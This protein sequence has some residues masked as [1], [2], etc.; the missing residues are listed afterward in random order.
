M[1]FSLG[2]NTA[3][4]YE[5][6]S[7]AYSVNKPDWRTWMTTNCTDSIA[8]FALDRENE[9]ASSTDA[10][11]MFMRQWKLSLLKAEPQKINTNTSP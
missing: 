9:Y 1:E 3:T 10:N 7:V 8:L 5:R 6:Y 2:F 11:T 4:C